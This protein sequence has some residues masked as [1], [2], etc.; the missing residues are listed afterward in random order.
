MKQVSHVTE[1]EHKIMKVLWRK[2]PISA[3]EITKDLYSTTGWKPNTVQTL[4]SRLVKKKILSFRK[5]GKSYLYFSLVSK[6]KFTSEAGKSFLH[7]FFDDAV[8]SMTAHFIENEK[9]T[10]KEINSLKKMLNNR[11]RKNK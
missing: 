4:L 7:R 1:A 6:E 8:L 11:I 9:L 10:D 3:I 2:N 5:E